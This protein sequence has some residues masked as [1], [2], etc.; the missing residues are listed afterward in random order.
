MTLEEYIC[1]LRNVATLGIKLNLDGMLPLIKQN[2]EFLEELQDYRKHIFSGDKTQAMLKEKYLAGMNRGVEETCNYI[3]FDW[4][5][6]DIKDPLYFQVTYEHIMKE[7]PK[8]V[9]KEKL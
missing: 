3:K 4:E 1:K 6:D 5:H 7:L 8:I 9:E 2:I